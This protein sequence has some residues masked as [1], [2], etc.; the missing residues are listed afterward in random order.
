[1][2]KRENFNFPIGISKNLK[3]CETITHFLVENDGYN[4]YFIETNKKIIIAYIT[5][6]DFWLILNN[7]YAVIDIIKD[8]SY[9]GLANYIFRKNKKTKEKI[10]N[11]GFA[12]SNLQLLFK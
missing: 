10:L 9:Y 3:N 2:I 12:K 1:M 11:I 5:E 6:N 7:S 8:D 4:T